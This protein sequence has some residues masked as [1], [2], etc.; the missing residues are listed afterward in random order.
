MNEPSVFAKPS[1]SLP[2]DLVFDNE[3]RPG[4]TRQLHN[5]YGQ[6]MTRASFDGLTRLRPNDRPFVLTRATFAG[7]QRYAALWTG[8]ATADWS[9]LRQS[10]STLL[11]LGLSGF[12]FAGS[13]IGGFAEPVS[14][15]LY[16]RW[17]QT[18]VFYP[19]MRAHSEFGA[20]DKEPWAFGYQFEAVNR[21]AI[22]LRY[23]LLPQIYNVMHQA[24][25]TGVPALRPMFL[26]FPEDE[27]LAATDDQFLFGA[28][29]LVAPVLREGET[30]RS[31]YLPK[32]EWYDYW[33]GRRYA[34]GAKS[35]I[36]VTL[37]SL[38]LFVRSGAFIFRQPVVQHTG[39][40]P[41]KPLHVLVAPA[42]QSETTLYEDD[43]ATLDYRKG[44]ATKRTFRQTRDDKTA[45]IEISA[46]QGSYRPTARDLIMEIWLEQ[47]PLAVC[48][49]TGPDKAPLPRLDAAAL[50][51]APRGWTYADGLLTVKERDSFEPM[52]FLAER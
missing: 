39:E 2:L 28:D 4:T 51:K 15:E 17:L 1:N 6:L 38:P 16:T 18:G 20:P 32:G 27:N 19:F 13:D 5:V 34:G 24:S 45:A 52:H 21:R 22:E 48:V 44:V 14:A 25:E 29:L 8:D 37:D 11:G 9:S 47:M 23:Q 7:G 49:G 33:T 40:M 46:P 10:I 36:P 35:K 12:A 30:T 3:G 31:V 41:G 26:E 50:A 43:G 42:S